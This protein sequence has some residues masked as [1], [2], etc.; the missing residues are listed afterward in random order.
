MIHS[1]RYLKQLARAEQLVVE[2]R[3]IG[4]D[5][6]CGDR[7]QEGFVGMDVRALDDVDITWDIEKF[8]WPVPDACCHTVVASHIVEHI[9][10]WFTIPLFDEA[11]RVLKE[12][13]KFLVAT[14]YAGSPGFWQDPTHCN[15]FSHVTFQYFD[16]TY[17]LYA[18]YKPKPFRIAKGFPAF[19]VGGQLEIIMF[20]LADHSMEFYLEEA[21]KGKLNEIAEKGGTLGQQGQKQ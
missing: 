14:P 5:L 11:W 1:D 2:R 8:P 10:P 18:I 15:G 12:G 17:P 19:Q 6:G 13:G 4:L 20:K 21:I 9:K 16:P 3:G 7:K